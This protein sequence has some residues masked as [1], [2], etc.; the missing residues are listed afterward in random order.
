MLDWRNKARAKAGVRTT[1]QTIL[2]ALPTAYSD[3]LY[4]EK[5]SQIY[6]HCYESYFGDGTSKYAAAAGSPD[7]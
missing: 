2:D 5:C 1:I 7:A 3:E 4:E 6:E